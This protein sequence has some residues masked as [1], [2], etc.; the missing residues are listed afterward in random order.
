MSLRVI[1]AR[2]LPHWAKRLIYLALGRRPWSAG[3]GSFRDRYVADV[4]ANPDEMRAFRDGGPLRTGFGI[5]LDERVIEYPWVLSRLSHRGGLL[6]DAGS[7]LNHRF[8][9]SKHKLARKRIVVYTLSPKG[10][11]IHPDERVSYLFG[12]L[13]RTILRDST[14]EEVV[15][16]STLEHIGLDNSRLYTL[17]SAYKQANEQ[18]FALAVREMR[19]VLV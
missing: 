1:S 5:G 3:Y 6:L 17:S 7:A 8:L 9:R 2:W 13:R 15:C 19:R 10:E 11:E 4:L 18:D 14:F 16:V 12:D